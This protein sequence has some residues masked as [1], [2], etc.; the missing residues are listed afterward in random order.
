MK[1]MI[2]IGIALLPPILTT[3]AILEINFYKTL[4][5]YLNT[6]IYFLVVS[7]LLL[8]IAALI[9]FFVKAIKAV[10]R[11]GKVAEPNG[12]ASAGRPEKPDIHEVRELR[13]SM[14]FARQPDGSAIVY[15][16]PLA[17][18]GY[19]LTP[20]QAEAFRSWRLDAGDGTKIENHTARRF[21]TMTIVLAAGC[22]AWFV[23]Q[24][25]LESFLVFVLVFAAVAAW[26]L[27]RRAQMRRAFEA[28]FPSATER[29]RDPNRF[30]KHVL[31]FML[32]PMFG[33]LF[34]G[35]FT[36]ALLWIM[37]TAVIGIAT[38]LADGTLEGGNAIKEVVTTVIIGVLT[39]GVTYIA[40]RH[41]A[42]R[43]RHGRGPSVDDFYAL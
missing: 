10:L 21:R 9:W 27:R 40:C 14:T 33:Q 13:E 38:G 11:C 5:E 28:R 32:T 1:K 7:L 23:L 4:P 3:I 25:S 26:A 2:N 15:P 31:S 18:Q 39:V 20:E 16:Y 42:F 12:K 6:P 34:T 17:G 37:I 30:Q 8:M 36:P 41:I 29:V 43:I 19:R 22:F 24:P 35:F